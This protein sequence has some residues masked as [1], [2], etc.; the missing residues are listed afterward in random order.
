LSKPSDAS[1]ANKLKKGRRKMFILPNSSQDYRNW[2]YCCIQIRNLQK[3]LD[4][5]SACKVV[6]MK[7]YYFIKTKS[8]NQYNKYCLD[9]CHRISSKICRYI[10]MRDNM[11]AKLN[12]PEKHLLQVE[13][14]LNMIGNVIQVSNRHGK[15]TQFLALNEC[16][17]NG[18]TINNLDNYNLL[19]LGYGKKIS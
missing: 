13:D 18:K 9:K 14:M 2:A 6:T 19:S 5:Y 15:N 10:K 8:K 16:S 4:S 7:D 17:S 3:S 11:A 1:F 12:N